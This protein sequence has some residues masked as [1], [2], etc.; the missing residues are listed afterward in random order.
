MLRRTKTILSTSHFTALYDKRYHTG[1]E[2]KKAL[3][4]GVEVMV[5][6][7]ATSSNAPDENYNMSHFVYGE[8]NDTYTCPEG[9]ILTTNGNWNKK[10][11]TEI[12]TRLNITKRMPA[13][14]ALQEHY[15]QPQEME[16]L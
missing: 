13:V 7:P 16:D 9:Q 3:E 15:V 8:L 4:M 14:H 10:V 11:K 12:I 1:I 2:M 6:I 5:A